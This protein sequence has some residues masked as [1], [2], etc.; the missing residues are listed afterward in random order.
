VLLNVDSATKDTVQD[1]LQGGWLGGWPV[2]EWSRIESCAFSLSQKNAHAGMGLNAFM[3]N[4]N[5]SCLLVQ[6]VRA[7]LMVG[8][9]LSHAQLAQRG[10]RGLGG[11]G[12][13]VSALRA[14]F[15]GPL[16]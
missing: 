14:T 16:D 5:L 4:P 2:G 10:A 12:A 1:E 13:R 11:N 3:S 8:L 6:R 15:Y 9:G 7:F